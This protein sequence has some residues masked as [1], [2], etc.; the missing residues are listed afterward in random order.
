MPEPQNHVRPGDLITAEFMNDL[1]ARIDALTARVDELEEE[2][3]NNVRIDGFQP[4]AED[5][6]PLGRMMTIFGTGFLVP[7][8]ENEVLIDDV[9]IPDAA[10]NNLDSS[11]VAISLLLSADLF[12]D[13][14]SLPEQGRPVLVEVDNENGHGQANYR[15]LPV[16]EVEGDPPTI[17]DVIGPNDS[18]GLIVPGEDAR[19]TGEHFG[20]NAT[21][22]IRSGGRELAQASVDQGPS[23]DS[24]LFISVPDPIPG[25]VFDDFGEAN[26]TL[27]VTTEVPP[28]AD[29]G[30]AVSQ[31]VPQ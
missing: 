11:S 21:V 26:A 27:R 19:V 8:R 25:L 20:E 1:I 23:S 13:A 2:Q 16:E 15:I 22:T 6:V 5:G 12:P 10:F 17:S 9:P 31:Q 14:D 28:P 4:P 18:S 24:E 30:I 3:G 29:L 7:P